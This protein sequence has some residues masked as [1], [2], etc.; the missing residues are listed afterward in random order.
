VFHKTETIVPQGGTIGE[1][2]SRSHAVPAAI[3]AIA[4]LEQCEFASAQSNSRVGCVD[5]PCLLAEAKAM[6][7]VLSFK[8]EP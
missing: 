7:R 1:G 2:D 5:D 3:G 8:A 6:L 4:L